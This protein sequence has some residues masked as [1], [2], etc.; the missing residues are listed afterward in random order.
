MMHRRGSLKYAG[1]VQWPSVYNAWLP[2]VCSNLCWI[3]KADWSGRHINVG[4][5]TWR[6]VY[7]SSAT[8]RP[9]ETL[10]EGKGIPS[11][12]RDMTLAV[13]GDVKTHPFLP[14]KY[15]CESPTEKFNFSTC[16]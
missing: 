8:K 9:L 6:A 12:F 4:R 2:S 10:R 3:P 5:C 16:R 13:E 11:W 1:D 14:L 15:A 7:S